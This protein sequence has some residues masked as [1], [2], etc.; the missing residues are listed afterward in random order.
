MEEEDK[1]QKFVTFN[2]DFTEYKSK[3]TTKYLK[4][5]PYKPAD[6]KKILS[7]IPGT[8]RK[9]YVKEGDKVKLG[10]KLLVLEAMK[11]RNDIL[12]SENG[13]IKTV[14]V[15]VDDIVSNKQLLVEIK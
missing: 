10:D 1:S 15:K 12:A 14:Y 7:F 8:I 9:V 4:R 11:M 5:K 13:I 6:P 2:V 3:L